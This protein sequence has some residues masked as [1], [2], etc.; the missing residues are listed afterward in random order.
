L[1]GCLVIQTVFVAA[2]AG[3]TSNKSVWMGLSAFTAGPFIFIS[4]LAYLITGLNVPL[5]HLGVASG[6]I[7]AF[8]GVGGSLGN[9]IFN[10][11][12]Q[13]SV[14]SNLGPKIAAAA[15]EQGFSPEGLE[16]LI[17]AT[18]NAAVGVPGAFV[19]VPG[20]TPAIQ[21]EALEAV[22]QVY[23]R[24]FQLIFY[25]TIPFGVIAIALAA[26]LR[27]PSLYL[28][29]HTAV[30]MEKGAFFETPSLNA[31]AAEKALPEEKQQGT[32]VH[33]DGKGR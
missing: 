10:T 16:A 22:R 12:L 28:T 27:D 17:P 33:L 20:I 4:V 18:I 14:R 15:L 2:L 30:T 5:R 26:C 23:A 32:P 8:R 21:A 24:G 29:N 11:I 31:Q 7:G 3:A 13:G 1:I 9:S 25:S 6:L 19:A